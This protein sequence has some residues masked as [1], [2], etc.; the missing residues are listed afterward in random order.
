MDKAGSDPVNILADAELR[1]KGGLRD[2][3]SVVRVADIVKVESGDIYYLVYRDNMPGMIACKDQYTIL[4]RMSKDGTPQ[5]GLGLVEGPIAHYAADQNAS[6]LIGWCRHD[7]EVARVFD[8][9]EK[10]AIS[11]KGL[12]GFIWRYNKFAADDD[13]FYW[14][15]DENNQLRRF[16]K[17]SVP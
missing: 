14:W 4:G 8:S 5:A 11:L 15:D 9:G 13:H 2:E 1:K 7:Y 6:Y 17:Q 3:R 16:P 10:A 12:H